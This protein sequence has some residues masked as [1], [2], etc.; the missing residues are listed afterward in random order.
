MLAA[1]L[2]HKEPWS[3]CI[4]QFSSLLSFLPTRPLTHSRWGD[5]LGLPLMEGN[6]QLGKL[7]LT[8]CVAQ[9]MKSNQHELITWYYFYRQPRCN[10]ELEGEVLFP[11]VTER[12]AKPFQTLVGR[13]GKVCACC[14]PA[15]LLQPP[16][17]SDL[18]SLLRHPGSEMVNNAEKLL[19]KT[20]GYIF[21]A[22]S[23]RLWPSSYC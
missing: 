5:F 20:D 12:G 19:C 21:I 10:W 2:S 15:L 23:E 14:R 6:F 7:H 1:I 13:P 18:A 9:H 3:E 8:K 22:T 17:A 4:T 16:S 11:T